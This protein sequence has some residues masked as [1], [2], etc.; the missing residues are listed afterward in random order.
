MQCHAVTL[1]LIGLCPISISVADIFSYMLCQLFKI[2]CQAFSSYH[3]Q[4]DRQQ[5]GQAEYS[6]VD[7]LNRN[8]KKYVD[9]NILYKNFNF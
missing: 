5:L 2:I 6:V 7:K 1:T 4:T 3:I 9:L 8:Y